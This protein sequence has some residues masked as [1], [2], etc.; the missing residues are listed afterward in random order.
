MPGRCHQQ[1]PGAPTTDAIRQIRF[2]LKKRSR[3]GNGCIFVSSE[4][5]GPVVC[6]DFET[7]SAEPQCWPPVGQGGGPAAGHR[8]RCP[9]RLVAAVAM[10]NALVW[11]QD[12]SLPP[13]AP[14]PLRPVGGGGG[15]P[16]QFFPHRQILITLSGFRVCFE[17]AVGVCARGKMLG[18]LIGRPPPKPDH[19][20]NSTPHT[21]NGPSFLSPPEP[22]HR[23]SGIDAL[24]PPRGA[25]SRPFASGCTPTA[26]P[27]PRLTS[28][29]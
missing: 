3:F 1:I 24:G 5:F 25:P 22:F 12:P 18:T 7:R 13:Q 14:P 21:Q 20:R 9:V 8:R 23:V 16:A 6:I 19:R 4:R 17:W 27:S 11:V 2:N 29:G 15:Q 26:A 28:P 10:T